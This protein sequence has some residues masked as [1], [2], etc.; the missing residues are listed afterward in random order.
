MCGCTAPEVGLCDWVALRPLGRGWRPQVLEQEWQAH[1]VEAL[2]AIGQAA[3]VSSREPLRQ[4]AAAW[5]RGRRLQTRP[6]ATTKHDALQ[7]AEAGQLDP[8]VASAGR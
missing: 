7:A 3:G 6:P 5:T 2:Q 1:G 8:P 4:P